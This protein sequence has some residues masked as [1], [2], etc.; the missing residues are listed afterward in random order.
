MSNEIDTKKLMRQLVGALSFFGI[1]TLL[2]GIN[3]HWTVALMAAL[4]VHETGHAIV[5][6][7]RGVQNAG[8]YFH[9]FGM[10]VMLKGNIKPQ[11]S[12]AI[13]LAGP[14]F[15]MLPAMVAFI[16]FIWTGKDTLAGF[17]IV[18]TI[19]NLFNL[20]PLNPLDGG[21]VT[22]ALLGS[23]SPYASKYFAAACLLGCLVLSYYAGPV[24]LLL[25]YFGWVE[26]RQASQLLKLNQTRLDVIRDFA[27]VY[28]VEATASAVIAARKQ[29]EQNPAEIDRLS[30][31]FATEIEWH[32]L[33]V[34][35]GNDA[36]ELDS[37]LR[38]EPPPQLSLGRAGLWLAVYGATVLSLAYFAFMLSRF[39]P[40][41]TAFA[42]MRY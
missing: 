21:R 18:A 22:H 13:S 17:A 34:V 12:P 37:F 9:P 19:I 38:K 27:A 7:S 30:L 25:A 31:E 29:H 20:L 14:V 10:V 28:H 42:M 1:W 24:F 40:I 23:L 6:K 3:W 4:Y 36:E 39:V 16:A 35:F 2:F 33:R 11:D 41:Q 26:Y 15:G 32:D 5:A 8:M